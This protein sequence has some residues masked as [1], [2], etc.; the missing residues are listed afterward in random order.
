MAKG[1]LKLSK[2]IIGIGGTSKGV[3]I[4]VDWFD[5]LDIDPEKDMVN[6]EVNVRTSC[7]KITTAD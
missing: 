2:P 7:I 1:K 3:I 6:M 4:P 5:L